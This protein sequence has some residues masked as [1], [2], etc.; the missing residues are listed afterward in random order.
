MQ[1]YITDKLPVAVAVLQGVLT[2]IQTENGNLICRNAAGKTQVNTFR[3]LILQGHD[4]D[5]YLAAQ[6]VNLQQRAFHDTVGKDGILCKAQVVDGQRAFMVHVELRAHHVVNDQTTLTLLIEEAGSVVHR[7]HHTAIQNNITATTQ[8][9]H[10]CRGTF[11]AQRT[12]CKIHHR[13]GRGTIEHLEHAF[14]HLHRALG[15]HSATNSQG[16]FTLLGQVTRS[17][18]AHIAEGRQGTIHHIHIGGLSA[19]SQADRTLNATFAVGSDGASIFKEVERT[20]RVARA[21]N[22]CIFKNK[23]ALAGERL[24]IFTQFQRTTINGNGILIGCTPVKHVTNGKIKRALHHHIVAE[25]AISGFRQRGTVCHVNSTTTDICGTDA[26]RQRGC[27]LNGNRQLAAGAHGNRT[28]GVTSGLHRQ[29]TFQHSANRCHCTLTSQNQVSSGFHRQFRGCHS[30]RYR[31][32]H[33]ALVAR[34]GNE[35]IVGECYT[36]I[37]SGTLCPGQG[38]T[39]APDYL[40]LEGEH[41]RAVQHPGA[42]ALVTRY[43]HLTGC[44]SAAIHREELVGLTTGP[45]TQV[46]NSRIFINSQCTTAQ[47]HGTSNLH[48]TIQIGIGSQRLTGAQIQNTTVLQVDNGRES[49][50]GVQREHTTC[51]NAHIRAVHVTCTGELELTFTHI[52]GVGESAGGSHFHDTIAQLL[53]TAATITIYQA[54]RHKKVCGIGGIDI[55]VATYYV[56]N[57]AF[58]IATVAIV[59]SLDGAST[60]DFRHLRG[61]SRGVDGVGAALKANS[62]SFVGKNNLSTTQVDSSVVEVEAFRALDG[63]LGTSGHVHRAQ[64][65]TAS[66]VFPTEQVLRQKLGASLKVDGHICTL[67]AG[68]YAVAAF[69]GGNVQR[70]TRGNIHGGY[71]LVLRLGGGPGHRAIGHIQ[72]D[73]GIRGII[74]KLDRFAD[75]C[76]IAQFQHISIRE[77][78]GGVRGGGCRSLT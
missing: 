43:M 68:E 39:A 4:I 37:E 18:V 31:G 57:V 56:E 24:A 45:A 5:D 28:Q 20:M 67:L 2:G 78:G 54:G 63:P 25:H 34:N 66:L 46:K 23:L 15:G 60:R 22:G 16:T 62:C 6:A 71:T 32:G 64:R 61:L 74:R 75:R 77:G 13:C 12:T 51:Q 41:T 69:I 30:A 58:T 38:G 52:E 8:G 9:L 59:T 10:G 76:T 26:F 50:R 48:R 29:V 40:A 7:E 73:A 35:C 42:I 47:G 36:I 27:T 33:I 72:S 65:L 70:G 55:K 53:H 3:Q 49:S 14:I 11:C 17:T 44:K 1:L 19:A 21:G